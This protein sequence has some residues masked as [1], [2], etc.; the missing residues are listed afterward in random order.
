M[1]GA[2]PR[3]A[4]SSALFVGISLLLE[5]LLALLLAA[6][7]AGVAS[8]PATVTSA[9][10]VP[11]ATSSATR[12]PSVSSDLVTETDNGRTL[13]VSVGSELTLELG[14]TYW[15]VADSSD[16]AV[17]ATV[18]G[19]TAATAGVGACVP[20]GGCGRITAVFRAL[21]PGRAVITASRTSCG[22]ALA[23]TGTAG[24]YE[25]TVVVGG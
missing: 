6:C 22:E 4:R 2:M 9:P 3:G 18:S 17:L 13:T 1:I 23:C 21:A 15:Q 20:G 10:T 5:L 19:P 25:V 16:P 24:A 14:S 11:V 12:V 7:A 8:P